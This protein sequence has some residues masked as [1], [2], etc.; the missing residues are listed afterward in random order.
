LE[1]RPLPPLVA[2]PGTTGTGPEGKILA[3]TSAGHCIDVHILEQESETYTQATRGRPGANTQYVRKV[4]AYFDLAID[5]NLAHLANE[6]TTD[7]KFPLMTNADDLSPEEVLRAY[8]RQPL[9]EKR[10]SQFKHDFEV[11]PVY[12]KEVS[13][14]QALLGVYFFVLLV[15]TLLEREIRHAMHDHQIQDLP[16]YPEGRACKAPTTRRIIDL[17]EPVQR[18]ELKRDHTTEVFVTKLSRLHRQ[19]IKILGLKPTHFGR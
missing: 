6:L 18:H 10:F 15:Q 7:R 17:F 14:I 13:R 19:L 1:G 4:Q 16:L 12:L 5:L 9:I 8:K 2:K 3:E 11:A